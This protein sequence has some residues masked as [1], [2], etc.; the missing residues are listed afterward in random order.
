MLFVDETTVTFEALHFINLSPPLNDNGVPY[1]VSKC[2]LTPLYVG[3]S[4]PEDA[5]GASPNRTFLA[6]VP[7]FDA[8]PY[9]ETVTLQEL[10]FAEL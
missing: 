10:V 7:V 2:E 6:Q 1:E 4:M 9:R 8:D 5:V 3:S